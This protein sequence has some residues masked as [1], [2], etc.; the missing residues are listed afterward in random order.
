MFRFL[1][2][3]LILSVNV[4]MR[5]VYVVTFVGFWKWKIITIVLG[6]MFC[7]EGKRRRIIRE[8]E[9]ERESK[10][11]SLR[12]WKGRVSC[13]TVKKSHEWMNGH[14]SLGWVRR[15]NGQELN[16]SEF[17]KLLGKN[18]RNFVLQITKQKQQLSSRSIHELI[19]TYFMST[20][21]SDIPLVYSVYLTYIKFHVNYFGSN[22]TYINFAWNFIYVSRLKGNDSINH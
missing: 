7:D 2:F 8:R 18:K 22:F 1:K 15:T 9:R 21:T 10:V 13:V 19:H 11:D 5:E 20:S 16:H 14:L 12:R 6:L 17:F 3:Q 4:C